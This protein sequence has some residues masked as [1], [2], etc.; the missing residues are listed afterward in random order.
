MGAE[1]CDERN[2]KDNVT[3]KRFGGRVGAKSLGKT[4]EIF[5]FAQSLQ[6]ARSKI[7]Q[8]MEMGVEYLLSLEGYTRDLSRGLLDRNTAAPW[9]WFSY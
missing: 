1:R 7:L 9:H 3:G 8:V 4:D 6:H 5:R 2:S